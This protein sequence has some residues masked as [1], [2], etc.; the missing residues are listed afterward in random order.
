MTLKKCLPPN[1]IVRGRLTSPW[2]ERDGSVESRQLFLD[3]SFLELGSLRTIN[4]AVGPFHYRTARCP[5]I[6]IPTHFAV[7]N[8]IYGHTMPVVK[9][10]H[11]R[12]AVLCLG[13]FFNTDWHSHV[14]W[15]AFKQWKM[16]P[17][18]NDLVRDLDRGADRS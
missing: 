13:K 3:E 12:S 8:E 11:M 7:D 17:K 2:L 6:C 16:D 14:D 18:C 1:E 10:Q 5:Y 9:L 15:L 4:K